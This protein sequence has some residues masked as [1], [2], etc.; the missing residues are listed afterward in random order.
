MQMLERSLSIRRITFMEEPE[1][2]V[3]AE[4][5]G[6]CLKTFFDGVTTSCPMPDRLL[7]LADALEAALERGDLGSGSSRARSL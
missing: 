1:E 6:A 4:H 5:I 3:G 7:E 2:V